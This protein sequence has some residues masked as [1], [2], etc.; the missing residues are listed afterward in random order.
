MHAK[1]VPVLMYHHVTTNERDMITISPENFESHL[2]YLSES[3][4]KTLSLDEF[5]AF[6]QGELKLPKKSV[7]LT[8]DDGWLDN[9]AV[10]FPLLKKYGCKA[11]I[12]VVTDWVERATIDRRVEMPPLPTHK[13][14]KKLA[15]EQPNA[16]VVNWDDLKE[17]IDSSLVSVGCHSHSHD[18]DSLGLDEWHDDL[19]LSRSL[20]ASR[21]GIESKHLCWPRGN[22]D[23]QMVGLAAS[24]GFETLY[25]T[26]RGVNV[27]SKDALHIKRISTKNKGAGWL[28][29]QLVLFSSPLL[30]G[31][32]TK[33]KGE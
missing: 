19:S 17:M 15:K 21:L 24:L 9:Y 25:T 14:A 16:A 2:K 26:K 32:Y 1:A 6:M 10:A 11:A 22:Y 3:G 20:L 13:A 7:L 23:E 33:M 29:R 30:G 4:F 28:S 18:N 27:S 12:F 8:F 31:L 5:G